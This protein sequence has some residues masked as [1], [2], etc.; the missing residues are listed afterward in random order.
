ME[1][2]ENGMNYQEKKD[3]LNQYLDTFTKDQQERKNLQ[4]LWL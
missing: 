4:K 2:T 1:K 3:S